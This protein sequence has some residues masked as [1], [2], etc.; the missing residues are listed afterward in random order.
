MLKNEDKN[1]K[2]GNQKT[3]VCRPNVILKHAFLN[4]H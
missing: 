2:L 1:G 4:Q 3:Q